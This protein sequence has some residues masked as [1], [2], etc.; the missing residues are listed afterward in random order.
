MNDTPA[1]DLGPVPLYDGG[2]QTRSRKPSTYRDIG[3]GLD[4][5]R[6]NTLYDSL[7]HGGKARRP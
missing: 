5:V 3:F 1:F 2:Q 6:L 7:E 4:S